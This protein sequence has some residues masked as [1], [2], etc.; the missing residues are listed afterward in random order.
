MLI[1]SG[2]EISTVNYA[3]FR[4]LSNRPELTPVPFPVTAAEGSL[5][6][7]K[8]MAELSFSLGKQK[9]TCDFVIVDGVANDVILGA[10]ILEKEQLIV[11]SSN[12]EIRRKAKNLAYIGQAITINPNSEAL[13]QINSNVSTLCSVRSCE[14]IVFPDALVQPNKTGSFKLPI[15][16]ITDQPLRIDRGANVGIIS[17][18]VNDSIKEINSINVTHKERENS[19][20][21]FLKSKLPDVD[22]NSVPSSHTEQFKS[23]LH[24]YSDCFSISP[25]D[26]GNCDTIKQHIVLKDPSKIVNVPPYRTPPHLKPVVDEY[27]NSLLK[28]GVLRKS[29]SPFNSPLLLVRK[30]GVKPDASVMESWRVVNDFRALNKEIIADQYPLNN[31]Y[32]ILDEI[33][34][35][36]YISTLDLSNG[37]FNQVLSE[38][39][40][41]YTAFGIQSRGHFEFTRS[42]QGLRNSPS[43][44]QRLLDFIVR[45][46]EGVRAYIDDLVVMSNTLE[47]HL[48][49][50]EGLLVRLRKHN[51][52]LRPKKVQLIKTS[53]N[54]LGYQIEAGKSIRPGLI[55]TEAIKNWTPPSSVKEIRQFLGLAGFFRRCIQNFARD[56]Q[57]LTKLTRLDSTWTGGK[58]PD[59]ALAAFENL[60][61]KLITRPCL[62]PVDFK[63]TF[64]LTVDSSHE[65]IGAIL[66]QKDDDGIE[67]PRAYASWALKGP[68]TRWDA[69]HLEYQGIVK[70]CRTFKCYLQGEKFIIRTDHKPLAQV[71]SRKKGQTFDKF[72]LDLAAFN[73]DIQYIKGEVMPSDALSRSVNA[74]DSVFDL[75]RSLNINWSQLKDLQKQ[76]K[77]LKALAVFFNYDQMPKNEDL[78]NFV[79]QHKHSSVMK[80]GVVCHKMGDKILAFAPTGLKSSLLIMSHESPLAGHL[81]PERTYHRLLQSNWFWSDMK[82]E[83]TW[84]V[85]GCQVC[86]V[87]NPMRPDRPMPLRPLPT[88]QKFNDR[89]HMDLLGPLTP[90]IDGNKYV[91]VIIDAFSRFAEVKGIPGKDKESV[92]QGFIDAW[93][94]RHSCPILAVSDGGGEWTNGLFKT[95]CEKLGIHHITTSPYHPMSNGLAESMV[96]SVVTYFRKYVEKNELWSIFLP[97]LQFS[98]NTA[99]HSTIKT[100]P[101]EAAFNRTPVLPG[102]LIVPNSVI[103]YSESSVEQSLN[104]MFVLRSNII[105]EQEQSFL[106]YKQQ[107]DKKASLK[108]VEI[109]DKVMFQGPSDPKLAKKFQRKFKDLIY[110][111]VDLLSNDNVV[112]IPYGTV[113]RKITVHKNNIKVLPFLWQLYD[114]TGTV[115][116]TEEEPAENTVQNYPLLNVTTEDEIPEPFTVPMAYHA[117]QP[118]TS[119]NKRIVDQNPTQVEQS[120]PQF[121]PTIPSA[122]TPFHTPRAPLYGWRGT[123]DLL[124]SPSSTSS[125]PGFKTAMDPEDSYFADGGSFIDSPSSFSVPFSSTKIP[126]SGPI[127]RSDTKMAQNPILQPPVF[128]PTS[129]TVPNVP[130]QRSTRS[131]NPQLQ[132]D[133]HK[134]P[135]DL[136]KLKLRGRKKVKI[137][138]K[139][140]THEI[141]SRAQQMVDDSLANLTAEWSVTSAPRPI[142]K[143]NK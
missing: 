18:V 71:M 68:E 48:E 132:V 37:F 43:A 139:V 5:I 66:S 79:T 100:T 81:D 32:D 1:D 16:N 65:G 41:K 136:E 127:L 90:D 109:G 77:F 4:K 102:S 29:T 64:I 51:I 134:V 97:T 123:P 3:T 19:N 124:S 23:L 137:A 87:A 74:L 85:K 105:K 141:P 47:E 2:A 10:D 7:T 110:V 27:I 40:R 52:K 112:L 111:V 91:L 89:V 88:A 22:F 86:Q 25:E 95:I 131:S 119:K 135:A 121:S 12:K 49:R 115:S 98:H 106:E 44:F 59:Q 38:E 34:G 63:K 78:K 140:D 122:S 58:L 129:P 128:D 103:N 60:K 117:Y 8:G 15:Q 92:A 93:L 73:F 11:D 56:S 138:E 45:D 46:L 107:F 67:R 125:S 33:A 17:L 99:F 143:K 31:I 55:K 14:G 75:K 50:M 84:F 21:T 61:E 120:S 104:R 69:F 9:M 26:I 101:F 83:V 142:R 35:H 96:R 76:D 53:I 94:C 30:H 13:V 113:G 57:H 133:V 108:K 42:A 70:A 24:K 6:R 118:S 116:V 114:A 80:D 130:V 20:S 28:T 39:S 36:K 72:L 54:Y 62:A 126:P 82:S